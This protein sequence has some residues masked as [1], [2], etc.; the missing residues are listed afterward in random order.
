[1]SLENELHALV[2]EI[3]GVATVYT[4]DPL[5][6]S[7]ARQIGAKLSQNSDAAHSFVDLSEENHG[8]AHVVTV[9]MRVGSDGSVPAP[10]VARTVA[11]Q[12]RAHVGAA[13]PDIHVVAA[14]EIS[15]IAR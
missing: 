1:M 5:W 10:H 15:A 13:H 7:F 12:I 6:R 9:R 14:V 4:V 3:E 11:S 2:T 8:D